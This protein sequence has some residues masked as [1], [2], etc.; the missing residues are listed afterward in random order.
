MPSRAPL[1]H[2]EQS[3]PVA[4]APHENY[5]NLPAR[6]LIVSTIDAP[7]PA[8]LG[9]AL[10]N[11][12]W[13]VECVCPTRHVLM[14]TRV[15]RRTHRYKGLSP[16]N[17]ISHAI[18]VASPSL[19]LP[20]D[21]LAASHLHEL[22]RQ[23]ES[24]G[25]EGKRICGLIEESL[26]EKESFATIASRVAFLQVARDQGIR[27]SE[28]ASIRDLAGLKGWTQRVGF[29]CVLKADGTSGGDGVRIVKSST[30]ARR[31]FRALHAPPLLA[32]AAKRALLDRD[33]TLV[34]P[35]ILRRNHPVMAQAFV[36]GSEATSL[37]AC[38]K[39]EVLAALHFE[40]INKQDAGGPSTVLRLIENPEMKEAGE[41]I[42]RKLKLS[43]LHGLD[44][45][46][47]SGTRNAYL[48]E[49]NPRAT[50]VGHLTLGPGRDLP[51]ALFAAVTGGVVRPAPKL[52]E[53][54]TIAL[55]PQEWTRDPESPLL[56]SSY[57]DV[58]WDEPE[59]VRYYARK[60]WK[61]GDRKFQQEW[62]EQAS[63]ERL[64][65]S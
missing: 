3:T 65:R 51:A 6:A 43:G 35:A 2:L 48:L 29:P 59:F 4:D 12:G 63:M 62:I 19:I 17:S 57:H 26:G 27:V 31:A 47:E 36:A 5:V 44:F 54:E 28:F 13:T 11:A 8:R 32:R 58:P 1:P 39:G 37:M 16:L 64:P 52:T 41:K 24:R 9:I 30:E 15:I 50:Q 14:E 42:A 46:L 49:L 18:E 61:R 33:A 23:G 7:A 56:Q 45:I 38:W 25:K 10:T 55:F 20:T 22:H 21:D 34:W 60:H 53:K 40:V